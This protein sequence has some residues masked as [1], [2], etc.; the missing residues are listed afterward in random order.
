MI[1]YLSEIKEKT[2][3]IVVVGSPILVEDVIN[4]TLNGLPAS[5]NSF[6]TSIR[7]NLQPIILDDL[8]SLLCI[9]EGIISRETSKQDQSPF[10]G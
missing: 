2:Y 8:Y 5:Y 9:E 7:T 4:Y 1:E 6:N 3:L 10:L